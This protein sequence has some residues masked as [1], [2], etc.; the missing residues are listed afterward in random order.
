[1][2]YKIFVFGWGVF[3]LFS[4]STKGKSSNYQPESLIDLEKIDNTFIISKYYN[5]LL[6][7][8]LI[9]EDL[10][11]ISYH[12]FSLLT[13]RFDENKIDPV[14]IKDSLFYLKSNNQNKVIPQSFLKMRSEKGPKPDELFGF[15]FRINSIIKKDTIAKLNNIAFSEL[16]MVENE[17][18][19]F[20]LI[21]ATKSISENDTNK[22]LL[23]NLIN[24]LKTKYGNPDIFKSKFTNHDFY[25][26]NFNN[27]LIRLMPSVT[28]HGEYKD[29]VEYSERFI[30]IDYVIFNKK[31]I[32][33][34]KSMDYSRF[35]WHEFDFSN[36]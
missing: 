4:C 17:N 28:I 5:N 24:Y 33:T 3:F 6:D 35:S 18:E 8:Q 23:D 2:L 21:M 32:P 19:N 29:G 10:K 9:P 34:L 12:D 15:E 36:Y 20:V 16:Y 1:M 30:N 27:T 26:W 11:N 25:D 14:F 7:K 31:Y 22:E 13:H